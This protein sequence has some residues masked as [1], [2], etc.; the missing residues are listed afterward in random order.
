MALFGKVTVFLGYYLLTGKHVFDGTTIIEV[1]SHHLHTTPVAPSERL[2]SPLPDDLESVIL[3]CLE[4]DRGARPRDARAL[5]AA[6]A[7]CA[8]AD[9]WTEEDATRW[10]S[11]H[12]K[13]DRPP[14]VDP[15]GATIT[16][17]QAPALVTIDLSRRAS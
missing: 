16:R 9:R 13:T 17:T 4:K 5:A 11:T 2:G 3:A 12:R 8:D 7:A 14:E 6:L 1:C 15:M 10:W